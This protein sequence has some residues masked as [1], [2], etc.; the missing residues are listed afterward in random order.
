MKAKH[1]AYIGILAGV[2]FAGGWVF[3]YAGHLLPLP[4]GKFLT[5]TPYLAFAMSMVLD[6]VRSPWTLTMVGVAMGAIAAMFTPLMSLAIVTSGIAADLTARIVP[7]DPNAPARRYVA[8][9]A[10]PFWGFW[11]FTLI[12]MYLTR[13]PAYEQL[14]P[15][16]LMGVALFVIAASSAGALLGAHFA[17]RIRSGWIE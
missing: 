11:A 9:A 14:R 13:N 17:R 3:Y 8:A 12:S 4:G 5:M 7:G 1:V 10:Y 2:V 15:V 16:H 6:R